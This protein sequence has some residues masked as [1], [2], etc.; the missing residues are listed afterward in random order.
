MGGWTTTS[1]NPEIVQNITKLIYSCKLRAK[2]STLGYQNIKHSKPQKHWEA[3]LLTVSCNKKNSSICGH[4]T[5]RCRYPNYYY[6]HQ[7]KQASYELIRLW[8]DYCC[9]TVLAQDII[10]NNN[11]THYMTNFH[12]R[13]IKIHSYQRSC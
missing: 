11:F 13:V 12:I 3:Q 5:K 4:F 6:Q 1:R 9:V 10:N 2:A 8:A 7:I